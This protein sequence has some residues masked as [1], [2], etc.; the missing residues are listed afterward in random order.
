M[1][2]F[3]ESP[4]VAWTFD[5]ARGVWAP[6][7]PTFG[8][9]V[10][11]LTAVTWNVWFGELELE[12]R[13][14]ALLEI[15]EGCE[16]DLVALQEVTVNFLPR[17]LGRR[18]IREQYW[19]SDATGAS[20]GSYGVLLFGKVPVPSIRARPLTSWM[21]RSLILSE[22]NFGP[23]SEPLVF[24]GVH[25][26]SLRHNDLTRGEQLADILPRL[27]ARSSDSVLVGDFNF[28]STWTEENERITEDFVDVWPA[29]RGIAPG[30]TV[31]TDINKMRLH[32][33]G[34]EKQVRFDRVLL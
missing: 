11:S 33:D 8:A 32:Q 13:A 3:A 7:E 14:D 6:A 2:P 5:A 15:V 16:P 23:G 4:L 24:A 1:M 18:A 17:L 19:V 26:E 20:L 27:R 22:V 9:P 30:Y 21:G 31:D 34:K 28:C 12:A 29:L 10:R 25:L